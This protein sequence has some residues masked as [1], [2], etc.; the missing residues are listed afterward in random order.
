MSVSE[1]ETILSTLVGF[2]SVCGLPNGEIIDWI[3]A[4]LLASGARVRRVPGDPATGVPGRYSLFAA[5]GP[6][7]EAGGIVLSAHADVVPVTGQNWSSDPFVLTRHDDRLYGRGSSDMKGF[8]ACML[9]LAREAGREGRPALKRPLYLAISHDEE[10]GCLGVRSLIDGIREEGDLQ[11][12][13]CI[14]GEPTGMQV[15]VAHKGKIAFEIICRGQAAHSANPFLGKSA[16]T[17]AGDMVG[18][19]SRLQEHIRQTEHHD[20]R[21]E[22]PFS[23]VQAGLISGGA[24]LN[25]VPDLCTL[26]A[27]LRLLPGQDGT[28]YL[29]W[30]ENAGREAVEKLGGGAVEL[31][32]INSYPGLNA[33]PSSDICSLA[34]HEA[35]QNQVGT[36]D[37]GTEAGLLSE[38]LGMDCI[39][40]GPGSIARAH[41]ADEYVTLPELA[42]AERFLNGVL[43]H[44]RR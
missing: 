22:V 14:V 13:G 12:V 37:F 21:F 18:A 25:I 42:A 27:E 29:D 10:L 16:I 20:G 39:V 43:E 15:A 17:L 26:T 1:I 33:A 30:L 9:N 41:K 2:P 31:R 24:A 34:L 4:H 23:T 8:L 40:C 19:L 5:I 28:P 44:L 3:E 32:I 7:D 38:H 6:E 36:I 35:G 11:A